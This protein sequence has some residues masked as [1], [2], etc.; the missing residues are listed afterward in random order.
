M[1]LPKETKDMV[2]LMRVM[3]DAWA[4]HDLPSETWLEIVEQADRVGAEAWTW[5][6]VALLNHLWAGSNH[7]LGHP[8]TAQ[9]ATGERLR[10]YA[11]LFVEGKEAIEIGLWESLRQAL[12]DLYAGREVQGLQAHVNGN[13]PRSIF[14]YNAMFGVHKGW[15]EQADGS[16]LRT[17]RLIINL[18]PSNQVQSRVPGQP[19]AHMGYSPIWGQIALLEDEVILCYAEDARHCFHIFS[20]SPKWRGY[21]VMGK[22]A[23]SSSATGQECANGLVEH[24]GLH[25]EL[26]GEVWELGD[27]RR[28]RRPDGRAGAADAVEHAARLPQLLC[29][30]LRWLQGGGRL[31]HGYLR[32]PALGCTARRGTLARRPQEGGGR[33][34]KELWRGARLGPSSWVTTG[35]WDRGGNF[36]GQS[37]GP[38]F[39]SSAL[40]GR[41]TSV[42]G[43][44]EL[45]S[46]VGKAMHSVQF[47]RPLACLFDQLYREMS[48]GPG[49]HRVSLVAQDELLMI[50]S[51]L[52]MHWMD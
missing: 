15:Q 33:N 14:E 31:R 43:S 18:I 2:R 25:P 24:C 23:A 16:W 19:S 35:S 40:S 44:Q 48:E 32:R 7:I 8:A 47:C 42:T 46:V 21:F 20:P 28:T 3:L 9:A 4:S 39:G 45:L 52:P 13:R 17:L 5:L 51:S 1:A 26:L 36:G 6:Q 29:G 37:L 49:T 12:G 27:S 11:E 10:S 34:W 38:P 50:S 30:Q 41:A 22:V